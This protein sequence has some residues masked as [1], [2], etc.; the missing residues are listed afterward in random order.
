MATLSE[1]MT[2][3]K[4]RV[5]EEDMRVINLYQEGSFLRAYEW[6]A[7]LC[8]KYISKFNVTKKSIKAIDDPIV[9]IGFPVTSLTKFVPDGCECEQIEEKHFILKLPEAILP[10]VDNIQNQLP[11][12]FEHWKQCVPMKETKEKKTDESTTFQ[13]PSGEHPRL[14]SI[15]QQILSFPLEK[16]SPLDCM[17]FL[18]NLKE[19]LAK[20]I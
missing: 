16:K 8:V 20:I 4:K 14:T 2:Q 1:I 13:A 12:D 15:M 3:E 7:W 5:K 17:L 19:Q 18:A 6:S 11:L 10:M 9:F